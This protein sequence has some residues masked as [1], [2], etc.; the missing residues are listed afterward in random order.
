M[1]AQR[2]IS[3]PIYAGALG[4]ILSETGT[5]FIL[6][7]SALA[8]TQLD[9]ALNTAVPDA[10]RYSGIR[11]NPTIEQAE[12]VYRAY[13]LSGASSLFAI[14]GGSVI[15]VAKCVKYFC[16]RD[17]VTAP[18]MT[19]VPT[20]A[21]SGSEATRFAVVYEGGEKR[22]LENEA[23]LPEF[24]ILDSSFI[25][26][27]PQL[28]RVAT[29]LD[30]LCHAVE[31]AWSVNAT[32]ESLTLSLDAI[33]Q[34]VGAREPYLA[35]APE[36]NR[37]MQLAANTAGRA[38][39]IAKT[40][41]GHALCYKLS[42]LFNIPHGLAA[43]SCL[44][45]VWQA[46]SAKAASEGISSFLAREAAICAA[47]EA[48]SPREA[49]ALFESVIASVNFPPIPAGAAGMTEELTAG[50]NAERM[51]NSPVLLSEDDIRG[52]YGGILASACYASSRNSLPQ[53]CGAMPTSLGNDM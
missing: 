49:M 13:S 45:G 44:I 42:T 22:S 36:G 18:M 43:A 24:V 6:H 31:S 34:I 23:L 2:V 50:V 17:G 26:S 20:T 41:A 3:G 48:Q 12:A 52:I 10:P 30:A 15:D 27:V 25:S 38:I 40:T 53:S 19:A 32:H 37:L 28:H 14:G 5:P 47:F 35:N 51:K 1:S 39:N 8:G 7:G 9:E 46:L 33:R 11:P 29:M 16:V 21:G 4:E